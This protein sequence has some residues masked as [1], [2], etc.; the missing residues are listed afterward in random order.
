MVVALAIP[1][2]GSVV[3]Y[4][5]LTWLTLKPTMA[6]LGWQTRSIASL[7]CRFFT[8]PLRT[9]TSLPMQTAIYTP[10]QNSIY[11]SYSP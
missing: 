5:T 11:N 4:N 6:A 1:G 10:R 7:C 3:G 2:R 9:A 8:S